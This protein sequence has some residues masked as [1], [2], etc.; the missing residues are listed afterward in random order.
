V[1][2]NLDDDAIPATKAGLLG[3]WINHR[4]KT[5]PTSLPEMNTLRKVK[6]MN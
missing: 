3:I 1:G 4:P 6:K 5:N 2:D